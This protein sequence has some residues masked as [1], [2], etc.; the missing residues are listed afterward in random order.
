MKKKFLFF[1]YTITIITLMIIAPIFVLV[2]NAASSGP[3]T[4]DDGL[5][6]CEGA[7]CNFSSFMQLIINVIDFLIKISIPIAIILF[8]YAGY[9]YLTSA[10]NTGKISQA[11][12][13]FKTVFIGFLIVLSAWLIVNTLVDPLLNKDAGFGTLLE[14]PAI[15]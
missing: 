12:D 10:G 9:L 2:S 15:P 14:E 11:H 7:D 3:G 6:P 13:I 4:G 1:T 8:S 5:I